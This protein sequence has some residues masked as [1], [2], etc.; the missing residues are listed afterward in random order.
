MARQKLCRWCQRPVEFFFSPFTGKARKFD[1]RP[2]D[3][4]THQGPTAFPVEGRRA[5]R[6]ADLAADLQVRRETSLAAAEAEVYDM[7]WHVPHDCPNNP[8]TTDREIEPA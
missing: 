5:W 8:F 7:P 3:G 6:F 1:A 2:V 4:R